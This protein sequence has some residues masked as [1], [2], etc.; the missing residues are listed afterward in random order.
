MRKQQPWLKKV[1]AIAFALLLCCP[2]MIVSASSSSS[3]HY[4]V[5]N[6]QFNSGG[7]SSSCSTTYC[8]QSSLGQTLSGV[9]SSQ[10]Y[11]VSFAPDPNRQSL[12][13]VETIGGTQNLG[14]LDV[15]HTSTA[16][17][18]VKILNYSGDGYTLE[19][20]GLPPGQGTHTLDPLSSP[21]SAHPGAEQF[22]MNLVANSDPAVGANPIQTSSSIKNYGQPT[23]NYD[24]P[25]LFTYNNGDSVAQSKGGYGE[26]DY[27]ISMIINISNTTP[28][29]NYGG[30][31]NTLVVP[32]Y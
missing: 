3:T 21:T 26:T 12:M 6:V 23:D 15:N 28:V 4:V 9:S 29:G 24:T 32:S 19:I 13:E 7:S 31:F 27:T 20:L 25:N 18:I 1:S 30:A 11:R 2:S 22:G 14:Y 8:S 17:D 5:N 10:N 16:T